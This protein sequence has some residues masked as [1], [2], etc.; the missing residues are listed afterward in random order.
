MNYGYEQNPSG[1]VRLGV[2]GGPDWR[3]CNSQL[4]VPTDL[5][6]F[7]REEAEAEA[8]ELFEVSHG[9]P[10][11][12]WEE[13]I[14][15]TESIDEGLT[16]RRIFDPEEVAAAI[17]GLE[18]EDRDVARRYKVLLS[19]AQIR[20]GW[21]KMPEIKMPELKRRLFELA[22]R[23]PN[24]RDVIELLLSELALAL[25]SSPGEFR[26]TPVLLDGPPGIG[27]TRLVREIAAA[28]GVWFESIALA[29]S[30]AGF[31]LTGTN[32]AWGNSRPGLIAEVMTQGV[33][34]TPVF[35]LDE[36]D[37][38]TNNYQAPVTPV[39]LELLEEESAK[40][41]RD[42]G[43]EIRMDLGGAIFIA[44]ANEIGAIPRPL[45]SR[46]RIISARPPSVE[47]RITI[48]TGMS[49]KYENYGLLFPE[50]LLLAMAER[51]SDLRELQRLIRDA[52]GRAL[53][54]GW[55]EVK[56]PQSKK[57]TSSVRSI[58]FV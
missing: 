7:L 39:L 45:M 29:T 28:L 31:M 3:R 38:I 33:D 54:E 6:D 41:F 42:E 24:F 9:E 44:T 26:V 8:E 15:T 55:V 43:L 1:F 57:S 27:K 22:D 17:R 30:S 2:A 35:L 5:A 40:R 36:V 48:A 34:A 12:L 56:M 53:Y 10:A 13:N 46:L 11:E 16:N 50:A 32:R 37:K 18:G 14:E 25:S 58:G 51:S 47:E 19:Q 21:R 49:K 52:A 4:L 20:D 23:M